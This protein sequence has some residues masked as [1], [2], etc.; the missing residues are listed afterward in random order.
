METLGPQK[1][2]PPPRHHFYSSATYF[3]MDAWRRPDR[4]HQETPR[5]RTGSARRCKSSCVGSCAHP[6]CKL[7]GIAEGVN[8]L[9]SRNVIHGDIKGVSESFEFHF[10]T[11]L[12]Q[13]SRTSLWTTTV[14]HESRISVLLLSPRTSIHCVALPTIG[15]TPRD[16]LHRRS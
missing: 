9:H 7:C 11:A 15:V 5:Y 4:I 16:G 3:G 8:Y 13:R 14:T 12:T 10:A 6:P 2:C 1:Y